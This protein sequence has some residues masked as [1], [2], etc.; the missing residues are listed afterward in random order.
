M[1][2]VLLEVF[3][4]RLRIRIDSQGVSFVF[5]V[6]LG[7]CFLD[8]MCFFT[9]PSGYTLYIFVY[10]SFVETTHDVCLPLRFIDFTV[11]HSF[12]VTFLSISFSF[13]FLL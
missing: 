3:V 4:R 8:R 11:P 13:F 9:Y 12:N 1:V 6:G 10:L 2:I 7:G 5:S